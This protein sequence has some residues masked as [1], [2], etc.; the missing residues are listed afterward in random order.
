MQGWGCASQG[1]SKGCL[2]Q[3]RRDWAA[4][5]HCV[6]WATFVDG[7]CPPPTAAAPQQ[8]SSSRCSS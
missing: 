4:R 1:S 5:S 6:T 8:S 7:Y 2:I 3:G